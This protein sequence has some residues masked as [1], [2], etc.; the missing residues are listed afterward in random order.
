MIELIA[1]LIA[2]GKIASDKTLEK[3][4]SNLS[5]VIYHLYLPLLIFGGLCFTL[6]VCGRYNCVS[7]I[8][9]SR[10]KTLQGD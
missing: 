10:L 6:E 7:C 8:L 3:Q 9:D 5:F 4:I 1:N 2:D